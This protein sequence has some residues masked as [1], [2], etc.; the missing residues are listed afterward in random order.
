[1]AATHTPAQNDLPGSVVS[2][3]LENMLREINADGANVAH[4]RL[5]LLV[6][7]DDHQ[8]AL[9]CRQGATHPIS[10]NVTGVDPARRDYRAGR[11]DPHNA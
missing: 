7:F 9:R 10:L 2:A 5:P 4:G 3:E 1:L 8:L 11:S 6:I